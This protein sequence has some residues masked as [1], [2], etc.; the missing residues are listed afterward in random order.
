MNE[1]AG[2]K[3]KLDINKEDLMNSYINEWVLEWCKKYHPEVFER[4]NQ[5]VEEYLNESE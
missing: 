2:N 4:A 1:I 3:Y 5:F